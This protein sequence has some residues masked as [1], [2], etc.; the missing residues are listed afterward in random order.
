MPARPVTKPCQVSWAFFP[1]SARVSRH[2]AVSQ[3]WLVAAENPAPMRARMPRT[4]A[5]RLLRFFNSS[6]CVFS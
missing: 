4:A 6:W 2:N 5:V 1:G 3:G